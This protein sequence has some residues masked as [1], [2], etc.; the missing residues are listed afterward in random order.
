MLSNIR[1]RKAYFPSLPELAAQCGQ[2]VPMGDLD[3]AKEPPEPLLEQIFRIMSKCSYLLTIRK[4]EHASKGS[5]N[6][7][8]AGLF[9]CSSPRPIH[10][11]R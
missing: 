8:H 4:S 3:V 1:S 7:Y 6:F 9:S 10:D 2:Y 11:G 5:I